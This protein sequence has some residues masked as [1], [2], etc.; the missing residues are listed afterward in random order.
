PPE[1]A[2]RPWCPLPDFHGAVG[3]LL[4]NFPVAVISVM[5]TLAKQER[6]RISERT[7]AGL[8]RSHREAETL[9]RPKVEVKAD[10]I[11]QLRAGGLSWSAASAQTGIARAVA[12]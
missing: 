3:R 5:A 9:G 4:R 1:P 12:M 11:R 7:K 8:E 6:V 2:H 10:E